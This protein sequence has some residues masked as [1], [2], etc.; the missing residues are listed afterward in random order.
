LEARELRPPDVVFE[1]S[2]PVHPGRLVGDI[3]RAV[4]GGTATVDAGHLALWALDG[5]PATGPG[6]LVSSF[7][8][9]MATI[10]PGLPYAIAAK[11]ARPDEPAIALLGDGAF[12]FAGMEIDT[13]ARHGIGVVAVV[14]NDA[15]WGIVRR[16]M[17]AGF[18]RAVAADLAPRRYDLV[19]AQLGAHAEH[20]DGSVALEDALARALASNGPAVVDVALDSAPEHEAMAFV[21]RM[22]APEG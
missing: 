15:S 22:F 3:A 16:Q 9:P 20:V 12:G 21:A 19:A 13:A 2:T 18:K 8:T 1:D 11:L 17:E 14:G 6:R 7:T 10:G 5:L 4:A